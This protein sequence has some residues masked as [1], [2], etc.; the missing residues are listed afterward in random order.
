MCES[1]EACASEIIAPNTCLAFGE[2]IYGHN[3]MSKSVM[4]IDFGY[5]FNCTCKI[6]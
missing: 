2:I 4:D 1:V 5:I 6:T 3:V